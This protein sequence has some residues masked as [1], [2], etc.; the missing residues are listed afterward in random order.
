MLWCMPVALQ[1]EA[2]LHCGMGGRAH[3]MRLMDQSVEASKESPAGIFGLCR[4]SHTT[5]SAKQAALCDEA[6]ALVIQ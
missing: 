3:W 1:H 5:Q 6:I 2:Q 4:H